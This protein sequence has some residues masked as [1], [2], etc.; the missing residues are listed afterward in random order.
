M[1]LLVFGHAGARVLVFPTRDGRF[2]E[3]ENLGLIEALSEKI[4]EGHLQLFCVDNFAFETFYC[5]WRHPADRIQRHI[6][7]EDYL[8]EEVLPFMDRLNAH[9]YTIAHGASLGAY[10]AVNIS[11]RHPHRFQ[12]VIAFSGRYDLSLSVEAFHNLFD[13]YYDENIYFHTPTHFLPNLECEWRMKH[14]Q[15]MDIVLS[16]GKDDPF[17]DN[18]LHLSHTLKEKGLQHSLHIWNGRAHRASA[19]REMIRQYL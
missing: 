2:Y 3:Y 6:R 7:Y 15:Q 19:W 9:P 18:N 8:L 14:L 10:H 17:L 16:I 13:G 4:E 1:E 11:L 5:Y 12:K